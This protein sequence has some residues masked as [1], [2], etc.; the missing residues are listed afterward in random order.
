MLRLFN[1]CKQLFSCTLTQ[2]PSNR[3]RN[4]VQSIDIGDI[5]DKLMLN[6]DINDCRSHTTNVH[7]IAT[8]EELDISGELHGAI[9]VQTLAIHSL[10]FNGNRSSAALTDLLTHVVVMCGCLVYHFDD[11]RDDF[12]SLT[13]ND[14]VA[15]IQVEVL[16]KALVVHGCLFYFGTCQEDRLKDSNR[17]HATGTTSLK[18]NVLH[19]GFFLLGRIL[20]GNSPLG[21]LTSGSG[22]IAFSQGINLNHST[23][24][25]VLQ[26]VLCVAD[27]LND[28]E[29]A[30]LAVCTIALDGLETVRAHGNQRVDVAVTVRNISLT[31]LN[32][33]NETFQTGVL[34]GVDIL[35][36][37]QT[38][39]SVTG[40]REELLIIL[41]LLF[42]NRQ[43]AVNRQE[44]FESYFEN[45]GRL[46]HGC[47]QSLGQAKNEF[48]VFRYVLADKTITAGFGT[49]EF[50]ILV[51]GG[52]GQSVDFFFHSKDLTRISSHELRNFLGV[53]NV[54]QRKHRYRMG[55]LCKTG[56]QH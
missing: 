41:L 43:E 26:G 12:R 46:E 25:P 4:C 53:K 7:T 35:G 13:Y 5:L 34:H 52:H 23:I 27:A 51:G 22:R 10:F 36:A 33:E 14:S 44:D 17:G 37:Q 40:I 1:G 54:K 6:Q 21:I 56:L 15:D 19:N 50:T 31:T 11:F 47:I 24:N 30:F 20:V 55:N 3:F 42:V 18:H 8:A 49:N 38:S 29:Y 2:K 16:D 28:V 48:R 9:G 39:S 45:I 32:V